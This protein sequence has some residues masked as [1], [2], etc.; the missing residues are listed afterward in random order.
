MDAHDIGKVP[1]IGFRLATSIKDMMQTLMGPLEDTKKVT[2]GDV[3]AI[4]E[5]SPKLLDSVLSRSGMPKSIGFQVYQL[6]HGVDIA[7][8]SIARNVPHQISIEDSYIRLDDY[9]RAVD[10]IYKLSRKLLE[11]MWIDLRASSPKTHDYKPDSHKRIEWVGRP[12]TLRLSTRLKPTIGDGDT[13]T[14]RG[15]ARQSRTCV[16]PSFIFS[17]IYD[18]ETVTEMLVEKAIMPLFKRLHPEKTGWN[19]SLINVAVTDIVD[20]S[21]ENAMLSSGR[22]IQ[23]LFRMQAAANPSDSANENDLSKWNDASGFVSTTR[24]SEEAQT[25]DASE[26]GD[27]RKSEDDNNCPV[28]KC[29]IPAFAR[30]AHM[31]F[32]QGKG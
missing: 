7:D 15:F 27:G 24:S 14:V 6:L 19:I 17:T 18:L 21:V 3:R 12:K 20:H 13:E 9:E 29:Y 2:V 22:D 8:V 28:C 4:P 1:G 26:M 16:A 10:E 32:H 23:S 11:R 30:T 31:Q 5:L 25:L